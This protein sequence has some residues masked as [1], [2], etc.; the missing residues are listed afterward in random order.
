MASVP[1]GYMDIEQIGSLVLIGALILTYGVLII[2]SIIR[3]GFTFWC[4]DFFKSLASFV[5][6]TLLVTV[7]GVLIVWL[8]MAALNMTYASWPALN[9]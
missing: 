5:L 4:V 7:G 6:I 1:S 2:R 9:Y 3:N 8:V